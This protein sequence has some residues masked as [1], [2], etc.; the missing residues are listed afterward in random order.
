MSNRINIENMEPVWNLATSTDNNDLIRACLFQLPLSYEHY[1]TKASSRQLF[2]V[3]HIKLLLESRAM[4][5]LEGEHQLYAVAHWIEAGRQ[6]DGAAG[7]HNERLDHLEELLPFIQF[8]RISLA[9]L[10]DVLF[11]DYAMVEDKW[12][13]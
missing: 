3:D 13:M 10:H 8:G 2:S 7:C 4:Q 9:K 1:F 6:D 11:S 12:H 5:Q